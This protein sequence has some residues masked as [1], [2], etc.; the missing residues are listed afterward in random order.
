MGMAAVLGSGG[1][2]AFALLPL[3][4]KLVCPVTCST[5]QLTLVAV[6]AAAMLA[7]SAFVVA[8]YVRRWY[9]RVAILVFMLAAWEPIQHTVA[10]YL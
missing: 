7:F 4:G 1:L 3:P 8:R 6:L 2:L 10:V 5:G 9:L